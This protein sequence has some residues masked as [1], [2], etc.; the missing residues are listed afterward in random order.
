M[1]HL[2]D[3]LHLNRPNAIC[4][5]VLEAEDGTLVMIDCGPEVVFE[6]TIKG[7][8]RLGLRPEN[9]RHLLATH[10]HLDHNGGAWRWEKEFGTMVHVHPVG[11]PHLVSPAK[12]VASA[13]RIYGE[14][15]AELWGQIQPIPESSVALTT[16]NQEM[17]ISNLRIKVIETPGHAQ[18]HNAYWFE[19]ERIV[20]AGDVA[21]VAIGRGPVVPPC[22]PPDIHL[23]TWHESIKRVR[24]LNPSQ[25]LLTHFGLRQ[26]PEPHL[27]ELEERLENWANW[28]K[29]RL[30]EN[31]SKEQIIPEFQQFTEDQLREA[32]ATRSDLATY[33]QANPA[34]MSV[35]G[36]SRYWRTYHPEVVSKQ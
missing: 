6:N 14:R 5:A 27:H 36:L 9:V 29:L 15:M 8:H 20:F 33:E 34:M 12:L 28:M 30:L 35:T 25:L 13:T 31:K 4:V 2:I 3:S 24:A 1:L 23:E 10:I 16:D 17:Q 32:G 21:G 18:H 22:P 7:L 11:A 26:N 19:A